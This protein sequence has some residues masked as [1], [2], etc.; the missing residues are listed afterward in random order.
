MAAEVYGVM[1]SANV[2]WGKEST[3]GTAAGTI[4]QWEL[5]QNVTMEETHNKIPVKGLGARETQFLGQGTIDGRLSGEFVLQDMYMLTALGVMTDTVS[6]A[7]PYTHTIDVGSTLTSGT[8]ELAHDGT[9]DVIYKATGLAV[10]SWTLNASVDDVAKV[11]IDCLYSDIDKTDTTAQTTALKTT[12]PFTIKQINLKLDDTVQEDV[13]SMSI[14]VNNNLAFYKG[15]NT[16]LYRYTLAARPGP[17]DVTFNFNANMEDTSL[18]TLLQ[19]DTET[20]V[21]LTLTESASRSI[22]F[23]MNNC[24]LDT[25]SEPVDVGGGIVNVTMNGIAR[26]DGSEGAAADKKCIQIIDKNAISTDYD[27]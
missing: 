22:Q 14:S 23:V 5:W 26:Y 27:A 4:D 2:A 1:P 10:N 21:E 3:Y 18:F 15:F 8:V 11:S 20:D 7:G 24:E 16:N 9:A 6:G 17:L 25:F 13:N 19:D 12:N